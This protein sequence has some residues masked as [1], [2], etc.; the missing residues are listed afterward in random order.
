MKNLLVISILFFCLSSYAQSNDNFKE[1]KLGDEKSLRSGIAISPD[2]KTIAIA[3]MQSFPL[4]IYDWEND[5][6]IKKFDVG[7]WYAGAKVD[8]SA[9]GTYLLLQQTFYNDYNPNKDRE[10]DFEIVNSESGKIVQKINKAHSVKISNSETFYV[11]LSGDKVDFY[12]LPSGNKIKTLIVE[13]ATNSVAISPDE[14]WLAVSH[15]PTLEQVKNAP[16]IRNDKKA[17]KAI[18]PAL[19][20]REMISLYN[21]ETLTLDKTIN[22]LYDIIYRL[23]FSKD[24]SELLSYSI[25]HSKM[26]L[27]TAGRQG[28]IYSIEMPAGTPKRTA[29]MTLSIYEPD[30]HENTDKNVFGVVST[31]KFPEI[32]LYNYK[33]GRALTKFN[34]V[35]RLGQAIKSGM[36]T[37]SRASFAFLPNNKVL[38]VSGTK[39]ILWDPEL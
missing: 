27:S 13:K 12:E 39:T 10:V 32:I 5:K 31:D 23:Q 24:G 16:T 37:D 17:K 34:L 7:N 1:F 35:T 38:I 19:K 30:F 15:R 25:P 4:F 18:K 28:Y 26:Q 36:M 21:V 11:V 3:G 2:G 33:T 29:Y 22:E 20:Y 9:K 6:I 14:K 8:Y